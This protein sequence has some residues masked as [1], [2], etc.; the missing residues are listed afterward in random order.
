MP[1]R[2][3]QRGKFSIRF[4][5]EARHLARDLSSARAAAQEEAQLR[6]SQSSQWTAE[7]LRVSLRTKFQ[8]KLSVLF[9]IANRMH[10]FEGNDHTVK[11]IVPASG[12][13]TALEPVLLACDGTWIAHGSGNA[14]REMWTQTISSAVPPDHPSYTLR[15]VWLAEEEKGYYEGFSNEG[16]WPLCHIAHT[17]PIFRPGGLDVLPARQSAVR[18]RSI[19]G[20][21]GDPNRRLLVQDYHFAYSPHGEGVATGCASGGLLAYSVAQSRGVRHLPMAARTG[22][23]TSGRRSHRFS[24]PNALQQ[25]PR[26]GGSRRRKHSRSGT[27]SLSTARAIS[28]RAPLPN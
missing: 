21:G 7:R 9:R 4:D 23:R 22:R 3:L 5:A 15:R 20:N 6:E 26:D 8:E 16:L 27:V 17:R 25:F 1:A 28:P 14:D 19:A 12:L 18:R 2:L 10:V 24:H 13:V 11:V